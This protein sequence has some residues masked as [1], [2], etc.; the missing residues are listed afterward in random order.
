MC[1]SLVVV[2]E[3]EDQIQPSRVVAVVVVVVVAFCSTRAIRLVLVQL[4]S[5]LGV[6]VLVAL[7]A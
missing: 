1:L 7:L 6:V 5:R 4:R 2:V 3:E